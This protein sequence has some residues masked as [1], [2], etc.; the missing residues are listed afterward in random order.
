MSRAAPHT[1]PFLT[2]LCSCRQFYNPNAEQAV[3]AA[4]SGGEAASQAQSSQFAAAV[5]APAA[6]PEQMDATNAH[7]D[8]LATAMAVA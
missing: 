4:P 5:E 2:L 3:P 7:E 6:M 1:V 8:L